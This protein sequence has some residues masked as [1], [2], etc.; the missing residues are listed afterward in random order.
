MASFTFS[1]CL[2]D[3][4]GLGAVEL[5]YSLPVAVKEAGLSSVAVEL[6]FESAV[7]LWNEAEREKGG[8]EGREG[9]AKR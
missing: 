3:G 8:A 2:Q 5:L 1:L 6:P 7:T 4:R 9:Q